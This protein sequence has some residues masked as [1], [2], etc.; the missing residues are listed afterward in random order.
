MVPLTNIVHSSTSGT[1]GR[2]VNDIGI[3]LVEP[4]CR[5]LSVILDFHRDLSDVGWKYKKG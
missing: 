5:I 2:T 1:I 4:D 3:P